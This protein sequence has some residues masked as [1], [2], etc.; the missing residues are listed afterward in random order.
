[1]KFSKV[2]LLALSMFCGVAIIGL[3][4]CKKGTACSSASSKAGCKVKKKAGK[5]VKGKH[6]KH[7]KMSGKKCRTGKGDCKTKPARKKHGQKPRAKSGSAEVIES[8]E[9]ENTSAQDEALVTEESS[10]SGWGL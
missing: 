7:G 5:S 3:T 2:M 8:T 4:G 6:G 10:F 9:E 1:M